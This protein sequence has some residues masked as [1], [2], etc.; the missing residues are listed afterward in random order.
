MGNK[1]DSSYH[2]LQA[3]F[4]HRLAHGLQT[5]QSYTWAHAID[6]ASSDYHSLS[7]PPGG[8]SSAR[9][10]GSSDYDIRHTFSSAISCNI[11]APAGGAWKSVFGNWSVDSI[12]YARTAP[13]RECGDWTESLRRRVIGIDERAAPRS[14]G[15]RAGVDCGPKRCRRMENQSKAIQH[16]RQG[17]RRSRAQCLARVRRDAGR[18][19]AA[20]ADDPLMARHHRRNTQNKMDRA[21]E[22]LTGKPGLDFCDECV[23]EALGTTR[24]NLTEKD[25]HTNAVT[26]GLRR[27]PGLCSS[28]GKQRIVMR[29]P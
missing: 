19:D 20:A 17:A 18:F 10:R 8:S 1:A 12:L 7:V 9:E 2:A 28:C 11:P 25:L 15:R 16:T 21:T 27:A 14:G 24:A 23:R 6:D 5:L 26:V 13:P 22:F 3:Q 29:T 4:R